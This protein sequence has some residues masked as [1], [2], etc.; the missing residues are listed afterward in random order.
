M[1][2]I[3]KLG[4]IEHLSFWMLEN[5]SDHF[6]TTMRTAHHS[7]GVQQ[8]HCDFYWVIFVYIIMH[9]MGYLM[10]VYVCS[11]NLFRGAELSKVNF[12]GSCMAELVGDPH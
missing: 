7:S 9:R 6:Y 2:H 1:H 5:N 12:C 8:V 3:R 4:T 10:D 11:P